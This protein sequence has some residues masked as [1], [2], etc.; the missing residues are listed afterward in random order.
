MGLFTL[1]LGAALLVQLLYVIPY[2]RDRELEMSRVYQGQVAH[3]IARELGTDFQ[4]I[5]N[6]LLDMAGRSEFRAMDTERQRQVMT[7]RAGIS[8]L[9]RSLFVMDANG[10][11]VVSS[12]SEQ[13]TSAVLGHTLAELTPVSIQTWIDL[14]HPEDLQQSNERLQQH[15]AGATQSYVCEVRMKHKQGHWVWIL[16]QGKVFEWDDHGKPIRMTGMHLDITERKQVEERLPAALEDVREANAAKDKFFSVIAHDLKN[17]LI[18]VITGI[19]LVQGPKQLASD[20]LQQIFVEL[21]NT[22]ENLFALLENLL[23]WAR[24]QTGR[25]PFEPENIALASAMNSIYGLLTGQAAAK[26]ITLT[27]A[28][29]PELSIYADPHMLATMLRN[30]VTNSLKFTPSG[31]KIAVAAR[32]TSGM[33]EIAVAD[34]GVGMSDVAL[35]QLFRLE[36]KYQT[37]GTQGEKGTGLGLILCKEFIERHG[38]AIRVESEPGKGTAFTLAFPIGGA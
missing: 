5:E 34:T 18:S 2:V 30:L 1:V 25:L 17:A 7:Q 8:R 36:S 24:S 22:A 13:E 15:F 35:T 33:V 37:S 11:I 9:I 10:Q 6:T 14:C 28:I 29:A 4:L 21:Q 32:E 27:T 31:G 19:R 12:M 20:M 23:E 26:Q 16:D 38:G 3:S